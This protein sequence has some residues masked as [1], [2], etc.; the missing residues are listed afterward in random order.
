[1]VTVTGDLFHSRNVR[2]AFHGARLEFELAHTLF[3]SAGVDAGS[4]LLLRYLQEVTPPEGG[5]VLD[6]GCGHGTL[7]VV[8]QALDSDRQ[9]RFVDRDALAGEYTVRNLHKNEL[10]VDDDTFR[11]SLGYDDVVREPGYDLIVSNIPGKV[12]DR[13]IAH[14]VEDSALVG[15]P[16]TMVGF[17]IVKPLAEALKAL[18]DQDR[19]DLL[20]HKGNKAHEVF[21]ARLTDRLPDPSTTAMEDSSGFARG[22][23]DRANVEFSN[24]RLSWKATTVVGLQEFD[25]LSLT[26]RML[27]GALQGAR[28][29]PSTIVNPGQGHRA[30]IAA[31]AGYKPTVVTS[32]DLLALRVTVRLLGDNGIAAPDEVHEVELDSDTIDLNPMIILHADDKA[33]TPW[34]YEQV[35]R[36][37]TRFDEL[38]GPQRNLVLSGRASIL[39]RLEADLLARRRR[40]YVS[41]KNSERGARVVR[42]TVGR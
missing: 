35:K 7:G 19:F 33:H 4:A 24:G 14:I 22:L 1:M 16:G 28:S 23:Y 2:F 17:V 18:L 26:T 40:G 10:A 41:F 6:L 13:A 37:L 32:R 31:L 29:A 39:G 21:I 12:G 20:L 42:Y 25:E 27:R 8:L 38:R 34:L 3:S 15:H 11:A 5:A 30:M 36:C 9:V